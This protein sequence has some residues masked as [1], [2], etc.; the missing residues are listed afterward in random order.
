MLLQA[1]PPEADR[2]VPAR[3]FLVLLFVK[4]LPLLSPSLCWDKCVCGGTLK[5]DVEDSCK[6]STKNTV[7][8]LFYSII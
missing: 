2:I 7:E 1:K 5:T 4:S 8:T 3:S 6:G